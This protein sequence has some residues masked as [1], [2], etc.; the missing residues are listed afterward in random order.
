VILLVGSVV[1]SFVAFI[2]MQLAFSAAADGSGSLIFEIVGFALFI[3][4]LASVV[5]FLVG[6]TGTIVRLV[7]R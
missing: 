2:L 7:Q 1:A 4:W 3:V 6:I 5:G